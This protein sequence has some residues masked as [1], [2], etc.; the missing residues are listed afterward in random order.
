MTTFLSNVEDN[1]RL[2]GAFVGL[3]LVAVVVF[4]MLR[5]WFQWLIQR[6]TTPWRTIKKVNRNGGEDYRIQQ[7]WMGV[8]WTTYTYGYG[9]TERAQIE[10][11]FLEMKARQTKPRTEVVQ[12]YYA[13]D[14]KVKYAKL[15]LDSE[16]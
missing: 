14:S 10:T 6:K 4:L 7:K 16:K 3:S 1:Q 2:C 12:E 13:I 5:E 15:D 11:S 9:C 8:W